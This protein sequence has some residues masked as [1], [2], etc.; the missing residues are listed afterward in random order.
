MLCIGSGRGEKEK[1]G[2][3]RIQ[4]IKNDKFVALSEAHSKFIGSL[5]RREAKQAT[6]KAKCSAVTHKHTG[7]GYG[8]KVRV[9]R[10]YDYRS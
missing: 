9:Y 8:A 6:N 2:K 10:E 5:S 1:I 3:M 4:I 7:L